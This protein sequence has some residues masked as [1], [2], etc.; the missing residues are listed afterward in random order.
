MKT[1]IATAFS[2]VG[3][4]HGCLSDRDGDAGYLQVY[5]RPFESFFEIVQRRGYRGY[6]AV[7]VRVRLA[8]RA[9]LSSSRE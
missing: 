3:V 9:R 4:T 2:G 6:G 8:V 5:R 1:S 7:D